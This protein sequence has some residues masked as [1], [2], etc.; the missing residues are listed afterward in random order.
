MTTPNSALLFEQQPEDQ[1]QKIA[2]V[3]IKEL[4]SAQPFRVWLIGDLGA[5]KTTLVRHMLQAAGLPK[6]EPVLS[7][8]YTYL[9]EYE[10]NGKW[11]AHLD[12]YRLKPAFASEIFDSLEAKFYSGIFCEWP[13]TSDSEGTEFIA[14][15]HEITI[16]KHVQEKTRSYKLTRR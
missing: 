2:G 6:A 12:L 5:G 3:F 1:L 14:P 4:Q 8:T 15:T 10:I 9:N 11:Y 7:P 16:S 13:T